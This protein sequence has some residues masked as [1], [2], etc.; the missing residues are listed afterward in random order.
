MMNRPF[1]EIRNDKLIALQI[2]LLIG[3]SLLL[4]LAGLGY[5]NF[6]GD[7]ILTLCRLS[8]YES[9]GQFLAY[10]LGQRK[11]PV[12]FLIACA[13]SIV[14]PNFSSEF[15]LRLPFAMAN[16]LA[17]ACLFFLVYRLF[18]LQVAIY[19]SFLF[20]VNGIFIA[21]ARIVQYQSFVLLGGLA[22]LLALTLAL[23]YENWKVPG[24][25]LGFLS[26]AVSL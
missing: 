12:Q 7:E 21:F 20:A 3:V 6:Q 15:A 8:D 9:P 23:K 17:L 13:F 16:L 24:L 1:R 5:S 10:L 25:Y 26:A 14:D 18:D 22:G 2:V 4:R 11:G 19:S